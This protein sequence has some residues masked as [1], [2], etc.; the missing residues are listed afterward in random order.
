MP[1]EA[2]RT[3]KLDHGITAIDADY[4]R[5]LHD[6]SHLLIENGRAA[7]VDTGTSFSVPLLLDVLSQNDVDAGDVDYVFVTHVHLDHAGGAGQLMH[8]LPNASLVVHPRGEPHM[9]DPAKLI[10]GAQAV[11]GEKRFREIYGDILPVPADRTTV[12]EDGEVFELAGRP[13]QCLYTEGHARHHYCL[14]DPASQ[15][16]FTGDSF[17]VSYRELDTAAGEF[18]FPTTT[19][20]HFDPPEAHKAIDRI[21]A[22][23]PK[24]L[25]LT[26]YSQVMASDR[27]AAD[28]HACIDG[29]VDIALQNAGAANRYEAI[30]NGLYE[31]LV[32]RAMAHGCGDDQEALR[33]FLSLDVNLNTQGLEVWLDRQ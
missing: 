13:L 32:G 17:G 22:Q 24:R 5:P 33:E 31:F 19:P 23:E 7:F 30:A 1:N 29:F 15:G 20:V 10:L 28:M 27:L 11:Y 6:A 4:V 26:H 3:T 16:V 2:P 8:V 14:A 25:Y 18:I 21:M 12:P 9:V